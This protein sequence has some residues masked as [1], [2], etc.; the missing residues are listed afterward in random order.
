MI[1]TDEP[2]LTANYFNFNPYYY[3]ILCN[4]TIWQ[5]IIF[6]RF[7]FNTSKSIKWQLRDSLELR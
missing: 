7:D 2:I 4:V 3:P 1:Y 6:V 5:S